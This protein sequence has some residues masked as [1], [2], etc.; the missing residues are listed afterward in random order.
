MEELCA[1][2]EGLTEWEVKFVDDV[3]KAREQYGYLTPAQRN[4]ALEIYD[5][6]CR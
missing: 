5:E 1:V 6:H 3:A 2:E 4:K